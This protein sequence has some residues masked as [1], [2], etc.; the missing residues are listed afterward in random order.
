VRIDRRSIG[1]AFSVLLLMIAPGCLSLH[2]QQPISVQILDAETKQPIPGADA[3]LTGL[4]A[5][6]SNS[7][8]AAGSDGTAH[9][10]A[11]TDGE[12][13]LVVEAG[14]NGYL[15]GKTHVPAETLRAAES[16]HGLSWFGRPPIPAVVE[17]YAEPRPTVE[18]VVPAGFRGQVRA[19]LQIQD[20]APS[21]PGL[22]NFHCDVPATG[23]VV[24]MGPPVLDHAFAPDF[25]IQ[26]TDGSPL[27]RNAAESEIGY[28]WLKSEGGY[29][30]FFVGTPAEFAV[31]RQTDDGVMAGTR[32][33]SGDG[34]RG[35]GSGRGR[36]GGGGRGGSGMGSMGP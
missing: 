2:S 32:K 15:D 27:S 30:C 3:Q 35:G 28:W 7:S 36:R 13:G 19:R 8:G 20:D 17:L 12:P 5:P 11:A 22:R 21:T 31:A 24:I 6:S 26:F 25:R 18:L 29:Q 4:A 16:S 10:K 9:L 23:V 14:A 1:L 33:S 34:K